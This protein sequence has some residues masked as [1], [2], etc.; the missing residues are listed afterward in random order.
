VPLQPKALFY[1]VTLNTMTFSH[2]LE[3]RFQ[4]TLPVRLYEETPVESVVIDGRGNTRTANTYVFSRASRQYRGNWN[5]PSTLIQKRAMTMETIGNTRLIV[6]QL[7]H[8]VH[9]AEETVKSGQQ[10]WMT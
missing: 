1:D 4:D 9:H 7:Q 3:D 6:L 10:L 8:V 2:Y 5:L